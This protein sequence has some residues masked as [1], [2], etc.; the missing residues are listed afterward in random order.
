MQAIFQWGLDF[1]W[2]APVAGIAIFA[3]RLFGWRG[4]LAALTLGAV[5]GAHTVGRRSERAH[6]EAERKAAEQRAKGIRADVEQEISK[7]DPDGKRKRLD[8]WMRDN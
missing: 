1:W 8:R 5:G 6:H 7:L 2:L 4:L 3:Y